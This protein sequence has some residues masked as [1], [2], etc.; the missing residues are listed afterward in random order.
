MSQYLNKP[1]LRNERR[2]GSVQRTEIRG[3]SRA[4][5]L[6]ITLSPNSVFISTCEG[7]P[8]VSYSRNPTLALGGS[9][10]LR[11]RDLPG[12]GYAYPAF[13]DYNM[14]RQRDKV[15][16]QPAQAFQTIARYGSAFRFFIRGLDLAILLA[17]V[18]AGTARFSSH[19]QSQSI[20]QSISKSHTPLPTSTSFAAFVRRAGHFKKEIFSRLD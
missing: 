9:T 1:L 13:S 10:V 15:N 12:L 18:R 11:F 16:T 8:R 19:K 3:V 17:P 5:R 20:E 14:L 6:S 7:A 4:W 2:D